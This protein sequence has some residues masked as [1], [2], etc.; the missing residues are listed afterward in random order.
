MAIAAAMPPTRK[1]SKKNMFDNASAQ[2][3]LPYLRKSF[4]YGATVVT[5]GGTFLKV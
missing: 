5:V 1:I 3:V 4:R 2:N